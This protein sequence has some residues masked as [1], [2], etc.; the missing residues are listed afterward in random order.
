MNKA[1]PTSD[2]DS[3][4][5][6][7]KYL[8]ISFSIAFTFNLIDA[9]IK[10]KYMDVKVPEIILQ[11]LPFLGFGQLIGSILLIVALYIGAVRLGFN[12]PTI[13]LA[14]ILSLFISILGLL[15]VLSADF[16]ITKHLRKNGWKVGLLGAKRA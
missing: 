6:A 7:H 5:R 13:I 15:L 12:K 11:A 4:A 9:F 3:L 2:L 8:I 1:I 14:L 16:R 10:I